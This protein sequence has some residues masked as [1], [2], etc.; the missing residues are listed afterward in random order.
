[1][2]CAG[3]SFAEKLPDM[4]QEEWQDASGSLADFALQAAVADGV[5]SFVHTA[6]GMQDKLQ[7]DAPV[8]GASLDDKQDALAGADSTAYIRHNILNEQ[9]QM[10]NGKENH[11]PAAADDVSC[12]E[13]E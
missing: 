10:M 7:Q 3:S 1:M 4:D 12:L 2:A 8:A 6:A 5:V 11:R 9:G 13:L